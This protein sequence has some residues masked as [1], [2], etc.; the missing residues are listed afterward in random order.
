MVVVHE[1]F[2]HLRY[3]LQI[4]DEK[5][6]CTMTFRHVTLK[7]IVPEYFTLICNSRRLLL[8]KRELQIKILNKTMLK[9]KITKLVKI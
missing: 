3:S 5:R 9:N 2:D 7:K 4:A 8:N 1:C 6:W